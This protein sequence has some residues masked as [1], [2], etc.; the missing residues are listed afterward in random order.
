MKHT[1][2]LKLLTMG[3]LAL[4]LQSIAAAADQAWARLSDDGARVLV[5]A[6]GISELS[7]VSSAVFQVDGANKRVGTRGYKLIGSVRQSECATPFG[8][9]LVSQATYGQNDS[10][11]QYTLILKQLKDL[12]AV[13]TAGCLS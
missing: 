11:Y 3:A 13:H 6:A 5:D 7:G 10:P 1:K 9:A 8:Q 2:H 12:K 4:C